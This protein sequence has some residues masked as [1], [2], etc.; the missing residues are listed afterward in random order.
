M[1]LA[2][3]KHYILNQT[4]KFGLVALHV[5]VIC[6]SSYCILFIR[7]TTILLIHL[8]VLVLV[9]ALIVVYDGCLMRKYETIGGYLTTTFIGKKIFFIEEPMCDTNFEKLFVGIPLGLLLLKIIAILSGTDKYSS[10]VEELIVKYM[11]NQ[12]LK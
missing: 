3:E 6:I 5:V 8:I 7:N 1:V 4:I 9:F 11:L 10:Q 2:D 12:K